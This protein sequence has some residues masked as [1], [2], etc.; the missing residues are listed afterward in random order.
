MVIPQTEDPAKP[1]PEQQLRLEWARNLKLE[2]G[3]KKLN[4][5]E[6][7]LRLIEAGA[8]VTVQA[9]YSWLAGNTAPSPINQAFIAHVIQAPASRLFPLPEVAG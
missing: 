3:T 6:F 8:D 1:S 4:V 9:V 7:H 5:K 2:L